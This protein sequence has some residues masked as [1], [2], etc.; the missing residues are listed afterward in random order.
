MLALM[1]FDFLL[2]SDIDCL[3]CKKGILQKRRRTERSH[4]MLNLL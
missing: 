2:V 4:A 1:K 3:V